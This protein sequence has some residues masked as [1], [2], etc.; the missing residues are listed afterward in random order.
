MNELILFLHVPRT[1]GTTFRDIV[2]HQ[3]KPYEILEIKHFENAVDVITNISEGK[4]KLL[5]IVIG[6][7]TFGIHEYF[8]QVCKYIT[9]IRNPIDRVISTY[10]YTINHPSHPDHSKVKDI[11]IDDYLNSKINRLIDNGQVRILSGI[12]HTNEEPVFGDC[13]LD[14]L[15]KAKEN[16]ENHFLFVG[17]SEKYDQSLILIKDL[18]KWEQPFYSIANVSK[19]KNIYHNKQLSLK[20]ADLNKIDINFYDDLRDSFNE[21]INELPNFNQKLKFFKKRNKLIGKLMI[22]QRLKRL[23]KRKIRKIL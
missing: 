23:F 2:K 19:N 10:N 3:Y 17:L 14:M 4:V 11:S 20:I 22:Y 1:G 18:L 6:H 21:K 8:P 5:K 15:K 7:F 9:F 16:V 13:D 12:I